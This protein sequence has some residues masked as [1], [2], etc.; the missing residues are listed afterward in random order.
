[1]KIINQNKNGVILQS[2]KSY[3][4][5]TDDERESLTIPATSKIT[6][7]KDFVVHRNKKNKIIRVVTNSF[8][9]KKADEINESVDLVDALEVVYGEKGTTKNNKAKKRVND[10]LSMINTSD[11]ESLINAKQA[12]FNI[13]KE[14]IDSE[15]SA[16]RIEDITGVSRTT[17]SNIRN[18][19]ADILNLSFANAIK[20]TSFGLAAKGNLL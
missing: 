13:I 8:S 16:Y 14:V 3:A 1:M 17:L 15:L 6:D 18:G 4:E 12:D 7:Y 10:K 20:L 2:I 5:L 11:Y 9:D 19:K